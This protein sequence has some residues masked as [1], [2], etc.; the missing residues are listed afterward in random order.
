MQTNGCFL[1]LLIYVLRSLFS[2]GGLP[3]KR[4][5]Q[6]A[7]WRKP[8][9]LRKHLA[10]T[11]ERWSRAAAWKPLSL[12]LSDPAQPPAVYSDSIH[13]QWFLLLLLKDV[14]A[15]QN[16][17][18]QKCLLRSG[19]RT[20][21]VMTWQFLEIW[22][23]FKNSHN[24]PCNFTL[25]LTFNSTDLGQIFQSTMDDCVIVLFLSYYCI[26]WY[27]VLDNG[28]TVWEVLKKKIQLFIY[29]KISALLH[30]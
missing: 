15:N 2:S 30:F 27:F 19:L 13:N 12:V 14:S 29:Q 4:R 21:L 9:R 25:T 1:L 6:K 26:L 10:Q 28:L 7:V 5:S 8:A 22:I 3:P 17:E 11:M 24:V 20:I 18:T 16:K 23:F